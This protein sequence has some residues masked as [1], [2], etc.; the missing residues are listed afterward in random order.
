MVIREKRQISSR[1]FA[2][3]I[4][5]NENFLTFTNGQKSLMRLP[6]LQALLVYSIP[7]KAIGD[8]LLCIRCGNTLIMKLRNNQSTCLSSSQNYPTPLPQEG[9]PQKKGS[10]M[11]YDPHAWDRSF[12][13]FLCPGQ[14][15]T[16][17]ANYSQV[18]IGIKTH[19]EG[20]W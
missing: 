8:V 7:A 13:E 10:R 4:Q 6:L 14:V 20:L 1:D 15:P 3:T 16:N 18:C 17:N 19:S 2:S 9:V 5:S 11:A 12:T